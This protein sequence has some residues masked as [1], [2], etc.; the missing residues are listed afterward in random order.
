MRR[1]DVRMV[2]DMLEK[3]SAFKCDQIEFRRSETF[4]ESSVY[5]WMKNSESF[6][7]TELC[8]LFNTIFTTY[9][10]FNQIEKRC[11]LRIY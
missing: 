3:T 8:T 4:D 7:A 2:F 1:E 11:E 9:V 5:V 6:G 10:T